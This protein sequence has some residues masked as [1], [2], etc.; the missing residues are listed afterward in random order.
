MTVR[1]LGEYKGNKIIKSEYENVLKGISVQ[2]LT[3]DLRNKF[4][5]SD[6]VN[7]VVVTNVS[8]E[9]GGQVLLRPMMLFRK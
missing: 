3:P 6:N 2:E 4:N 1:E 9:M 8:G 5:L 7:G